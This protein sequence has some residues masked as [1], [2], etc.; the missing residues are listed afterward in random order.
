MNEQQK[1]IYDM[2]MDNKTPHQIAKTLGLTDAQVLEQLRS[3]NLRITD[4]VKV[5]KHD[6]RYRVEDHQELLR[7]RDQDYFDGVML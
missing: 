3:L 5:G 1:H 4:D 2:S 7:Q 6:H